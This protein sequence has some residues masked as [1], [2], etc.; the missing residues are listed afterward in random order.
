[1][2]KRTD[3]T[4]IRKL[5]K[6][7]TSY[8]IGIPMGII[9]ALNL[10][11]KDEMYVKSIHG[12]IILQPVKEDKSTFSKHSGAINDYIRNLV[13][14][15]SP[16]KPINTEQE[17]A[18]LGSIPVQIP[19]KDILESAKIKESVSNMMDKYEYTS[20]GT[21][22]VPKPGAFQDSPTPP[23]VQQAVKK[24]E[25]TIVKDTP[26]PVQEPIPEP[27]QE[28]SQPTPS[29]DIKSQPEDQVKEAIVYTR[30]KAHDHFKIEEYHIDDDKKQ[31]D[32]KQEDN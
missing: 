28:I 7:G 10:H 4:P 9:Q 13:G 11:V 18:T 27:V 24:P 26:E 6:S 2:E 19:S 29:P 17:I 12:V 5:Y 32:E 21:K 23:A 8:Q 15:E 20:D 1:M 22:L 16:G 25:P 31:D 3:K 14:N 30:L